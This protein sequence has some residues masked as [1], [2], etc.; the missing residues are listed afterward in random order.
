MLKKFASVVLTSF[1]GSTYRSVR[2]RLYAR[3]GLA[4]RDFWA[5]CMVF[6]CCSRRADEWRVR[7]LTEFFRSLL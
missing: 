4:E 1:R 7:V 6:S 5:S 3:C 2:L